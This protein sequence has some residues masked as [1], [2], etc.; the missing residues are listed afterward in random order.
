MA[1]RLAPNRARDK[2]M[3]C[4]RRHSADAAAG[5]EAK[6]PRQIEMKKKW[7]RRRTGSNR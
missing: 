3:G 7:E 2:P 4:F 1:A 5:R 6:G